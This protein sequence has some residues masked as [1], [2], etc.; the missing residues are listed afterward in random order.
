MISIHARGNWD[1]EINNLPKVA[2][3][4]HTE[5]SALE[6]TCLPLCLSLCNSLPCRSPAHLGVGI[7]TLG[8]P[9]L[10]PVLL[11]ANT[12]L[13]L[14]GTRCLNLQPGNQAKRGREE[15][16]CHWGLPAAPALLTPGSGLGT[17]PSNPKPTQCT[18]QG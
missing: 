12:L 15:I 1:T 16:F 11:P 17:D 6:S 3:Q 9:T 10:Q 13:P 4:V 14:I 7:G 2:E 18:A 5:T 8:S